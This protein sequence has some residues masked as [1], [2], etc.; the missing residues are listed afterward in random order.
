MEGLNNNSNN[1]TSRSHFET[2]S[3]GQVAE[4]VSGTLGLPET[5]AA[6]FVDQKIQGSQL[7]HMTVQDL[8]TAGL[9]SLQAKKIVNEVNKLCPPP[10]ADKT[11][12]SKN[13]NEHKK[14]TKATSKSKVQSTS[15]A[16]PLLPLTVG[17]NN[18]QERERVAYLS[19]VNG[20]K[21]KIEGY[22]TQMVTIELG[23][24]AK[25]QSEPGKLIFMTGGI[26]Y[27]TKTDGKG[28]Q[29]FVTGQRIFLTEWSYTGPPGTK[30]KVAFS[31]DLPS[32]VLPVDLAEHHGRILCQRGSLLVCP[33]HVN[34]K[35]AFTQR[36][37]AGF[38]G[39]TG[40]ILQSLEASKGT[41]FLSAS[42]VVTKLKLRP[43]ETIRCTTGALVGMESTVDYRVEQVG[44]LFDMWFGREGVFW[45]TLTGP[46]TV[47][48]ESLPGDRLVKAIYERQPKCPSQKEADRDAAQGK[49]VVKGVVGA[50]ALMDGLT[51]GKKRFR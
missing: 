19:N 32:R 38:F 1:N 9:S 31:E 27:V 24:N 40:F 46:G 47:W 4:W 35:I 11:N 2:C 10:F 26:D 50:L 15:P 39:G 29:R 48:L 30:G 25:V 12:S 3:P 18:G 37:G 7:S 41:V 51:D 21:T 16:D 42:G 17:N 23:P 43:G 6:V 45:T 28:W 8:R 49:A 5:V 13:R 34:I 44:G 14:S 33:S 36:F 20:Y 22:E